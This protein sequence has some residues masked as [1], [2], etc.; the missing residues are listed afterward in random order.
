MNIVNTEVR[1]LVKRLEPIA[2]K[3]LLFKQISGFI[4]SGYLV[5]TLLLISS[6]L[7]G[8][9]YFSSSIRFLLLSLIGISF[10]IPSFIYA[11]IP[12]FHYYKNGFQS[13]VLNSARAV[14][15]TF[16]DV[17]DSLLNTIELQFSPQPY[18]SSSL[19]NAEFQRVEKSLSQRDLTSVVS[20]KPLFKPLLYLL[21][22]IFISSALMGFVH[23]FSTGFYQLSNPT[24]SFAKPAPFSFEIEPGSIE[25]TK[26][27][28]VFIKITVLGEKHPF[29][30]F[31]YKDD[32]DSEFKRER[33]Y[34]DSLGFFTYNF[35][36]LNFSTQYFAEAKDVRSETYTLSITDRPVIKQF[37]INIIP[38]SYT[39][40]SS[41]TI[42][43]N[44]SIETVVGAIASFTIQSTKGLS[45]AYL[46][47]NDSTAIPFKVTNSTASG[48][49]TLKKA[50]SYTIVLQDSLSNTNADPVSYT[51]TLT[52]DTAPEIQLKEP[53]KNTDLSA[54][55]RLTL[56]ASISDDYGFSKLTL[57]YKLSSSQF[58][59]PYREYKS[60]EIPIGKGKELDVPYIW[61]LS[62]LNPATEDVF[63][64]YLEI[65]D[66]NTATGPGIARTPE[67]TVRMPGLD[68]IFAQA[69]ESHN[70]IQKNLEE[71]LKEAEQLKK[72]LEAVDRELKTD[73]KEMTFEQKQKLESALNRYE[74]MQQKLQET[75]Q[76]LDKMN[77]QMQKDNLF[78]PETMQKYLELKKLMDSMTNEDLKKA[79]EKL[80]SSLQQMNKQNTQQ[81]LE[82]M[83]VD[84]E[85]FRQSLERTMNIL[86]RI[87][88]EQRV[89]NLKKSAERIEQKQKEISE[90]TK[91]NA[92]SE[93]LQ[94][95]Q[96]Q[97]EQELEN[98]EKEMQKLEKAMEGLKDTPQEKLEKLK[99]E[100]AE[101]NNQQKSEQ[102]KQELQKGDK[103]KAMQQMQSIQQNMQ[104]M[105]QSF[106]EMQE[107]MQQQNQMQV[108]NDLMRS[109]DNILKLSKEQEQLKNSVQKKQ[110]NSSN[111]KDE[112]RQQS[113][114]D[115]NLST[116]MQQL[117]DLSQKTLAVTPEM[118][119]ALGDAKKQMANAM[120][121]MQDKNKP[122]AEAGMQN[123]MSSLNKAALLMR[124]AMNSMMQGG[125]GQGGGMASLLQQLG[126]LSQMQMGL[127][128]MTQQMQQPGG[129]SGQSGEQME[130]LA[131]QQERI[132]KS[133]EQL[134]KEAEGSGK[135][136][137][138]PANL[139]RIL[140]EMKEV[141]SDL[142]TEKLD[143]DLV[144]KQERIL[145][146]MLDAQRS[147]NERDF[148]K[149]RESNSATNISKSSPAEL[150]LEKI[151]NTIQESLNSAG[152]EGFAKDYQQLIRT[153]L[154]S[155]NSR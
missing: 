63:T 138:L 98:F 26:G 150:K 143:S 38:P 92:N 69:E 120:Q 135:S 71:T 95:Q 15:S 112:L 5:L 35:Y 33:L 83:K 44:G 145:S 132:Q 11:F 88:T 148:E 31:F 105:Q 52:P 50:G 118:G 81:N 116:I 107:Q 129:R 8:V 34:P 147:I 70:D 114:I 56:L 61:N 117:A 78:S 22:L 139:N 113:A 14:G 102:A 48:S 141:V 151:L 127:N 32:T 111:F 66:N 128:N 74:Q 123:S 126:Q 42:L 106:S 12:L 155:L 4:K 29:I 84:E 39:G 43:D 16:Q 41:T 51:I 79:M 96:E 77:E 154:E 80:Q 103:Q 137:T 58:E 7:Q 131:Q 76:K 68:E 24:T 142:R 86:K 23:P 54:D 57:F 133:L 119:K 144:Q 124:D 37:T 36:S 17:K 64:Y 75:S 73:M 62:S 60:L 152:S 89:E 9:F 82:Q 3:Q 21:V 149:E 94:K 136:K 20:F 65:R 25:L 91:N 109:L 13:R 46:R 121:G 19:V 93:Q 85:A 110:Q 122:G 90:K 49:F 18:Y 72:D 2:R 53:G 55:N 30:D 140:E 100:F 104:K 10:F 125:G 45:Q 99:Q 130:R 67:Y 97:L 6:L 1:N 87:E 115:K 108:L 153:Y 27:E 47:F 28:D 101:Q 40:L 146:R 134:Q 59:Q